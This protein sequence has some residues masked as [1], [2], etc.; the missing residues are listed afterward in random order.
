MVFSRKPILTLSAATAG[1]TRAGSGTASDARPP[2]MVLRWKFMVL[3]SPA[4]VSWALPPSKTRI[5][6]WC[7]VRQLASTS[8][9]NPL[10]GRIVR[11]HRDCSPLESIPEESVP[12]VPPELPPQ[13][14]REPLLTLPGALIGYILLL[15]II[16][17][18]VL[19][20]PDLANWTVE[21]FG[22]IPKRYDA[23]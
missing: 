2:R 21:V 10:M 4:P 19:L 18:R 23:T 15:A 22:F 13:P 3:L 8:P 17:L 9:Q 11:F 7:A 1:L 6:G 16:H 14:P 20:P 5:A 12:E